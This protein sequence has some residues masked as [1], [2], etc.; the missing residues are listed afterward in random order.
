[1]PSKVTGGSEVSALSPFLEELRVPDGPV[2]QT[3]NWVS[4]GLG[5]GS[6][7][8]AALG[9]QPLGKGPSWPD[10]LFSLSPQEAHRCELKAVEQ[11]EWWAEMSTLGKGSM[12]RR[13]F[14]RGLHILPGALSVLP[15][16]LP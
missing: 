13:V 7:Q 14:A 12:G 15:F 11:M 8:T 9:C 3:G 6:P 4:L 5:L 10:I 1:M 16:L 2:W